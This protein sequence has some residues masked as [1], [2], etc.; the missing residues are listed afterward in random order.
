L[1]PPI[2]ANAG[3]FEGYRE[4]LARRYSLGDSGDIA[5][6]LRGLLVSHLSVGFGTFEQPT[7]NL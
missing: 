5:P 3:A 1:L 2:P 6:C 7:F 4:R